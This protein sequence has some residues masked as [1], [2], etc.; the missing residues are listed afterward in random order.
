M[1]S[2]SWSATISQLLAGDDLSVQQA[3]WAMD[4]I[5]RGEATDA[6]VAAFVVA[7]RAKGETGAEVAGLVNAMSRHSRRVVVEQPVLDVVGTGGD[8]LHT[9]NISTMAAI[10]CAAVGARV[11][12]HGNR[13]ASSSCGSADLL[14]ELG[15]A[16]ELG[17]EQVAESVAEVGIGFCF[18]PVF[19]PAMRHAAPVRR[20]LGIPTVFN[21][22]GPLANPAQPS[23][24]LVGC[25]EARLAPVM[26]AALSRRPGAALVVR[27]RDGLDEVTTTG[28]TDLWDVRDGDV[29][30]RSIS[31]AALGIEEPGPGALRGGDAAANA[32]VTRMV[33]SGSRSGPFGAVADAVALNAAAALATLARVPGSPFACTAD[34][35]VGRIAELL[36]AARAAIDSGAAAEVLDRW[37][38]VS[39]RLARLA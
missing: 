22:L 37:V 11:V 6:Q 24:Q 39:G 5:M 32:E 2:N 10:V 13:A 19:H 23:A 9:V 7:L 33:F 34:A 25:A 17:P 21:I 16:I 30:Q 12:K 31:A 27:G 29:V 14:A 15:V 35:V 28:E 4:E 3:E 1:T 8:Q 36:P 20:E 38:E 26:A 18:A